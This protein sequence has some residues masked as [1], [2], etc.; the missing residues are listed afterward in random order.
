M[1]WGVRC[2]L[3][4]LAGGSWVA[5][6][7]GVGVVCGQM[8]ES[9]GDGQMGAVGGPHCLGASKLPL[10]VRRMVGGTKARPCPLQGAQMHLPSPTLSTS[11]SSWSFWTY[12]SI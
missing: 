10:G 8:N 9:L 7:G 12:V 2:E 3:G 1:G 4:Q 11:S 5:G 6:R